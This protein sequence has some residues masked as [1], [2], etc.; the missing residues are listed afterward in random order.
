M[1]MT[2]WAKVPK[3]E[4]PAACGLCSRRVRSA[5]SVGRSTAARAALARAATQPA[6]DLVA[7][8]C[9]VADLTVLLG[10]LA[11]GEDAGGDG[12]GTC[13]LTRGAVDPAGVEEMVVFAFGEEDV[14]G[15]VLEDALKVVLGE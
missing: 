7:G 10:T 2:R 8:E 3:T 6:N 5:K 4:K 1:V 13:E 15:D 12:V 14:L 9:G 11:G